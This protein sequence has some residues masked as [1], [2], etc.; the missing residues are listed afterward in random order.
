M[1]GLP[2]SLLRCFLLFHS[3]HLRRTVTGS[4]PPAGG[5]W[6]VL[7]VLLVLVVLPVLLCPRFLPGGVGGGAPRRRDGAHSSD[8]RNSRRDC[9]L[10]RSRSLPCRVRDDRVVPYHLNTYKVIQNVRVV[11]KVF[12]VAVKYKKVTQINV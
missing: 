12:M 9:R 10:W 5:A 7:L 6:K 4:P 2:P 11:C 8:Q 3:P 1:A